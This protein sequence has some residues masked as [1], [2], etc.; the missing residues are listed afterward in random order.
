MASWWVN[1]SQTICVQVKLVKQN[2]GRQ[3]TYTCTPGITR[4]NYFWIIPASKKY[5][6]PLHCEEIV[7]SYMRF[8]LAHCFMFPKFIFIYSE[9]DWLLILYFS[10]R[11]FHKK[12]KKKKCLCIVSFFTFIFN[13]D[14]LHPCQ[15][16][17]RKN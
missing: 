14:I 10:I 2:Y 3:C 12:K 17:W 8:L 13:I 4:L 6:S 5:G 15:G 7:F 9:L 1:I 11:I 16:W